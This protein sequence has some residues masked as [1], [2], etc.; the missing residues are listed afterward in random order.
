MSLDLFIPSFVNM[1]DDLQTSSAWVQR[2]ISLY[3]FGLLLGAL[4]AGPISDAYGRR[5][6]LLWS[7]AIA[8]MIFCGAMQAQSIAL[9]LTLRC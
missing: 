3:T 8:V 1:V 6:V 7:T 9:L 2:L 5:H 4:V